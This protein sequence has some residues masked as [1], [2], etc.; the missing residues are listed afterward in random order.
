[1]L[2]LA[3]ALSQ[4]ADVTVAFRSIPE[5]V[6]SGEYKVIA[7]EPHA[8]T[9]SDAKDD[10]ATRGLHPFRHMSYCRRLGLFPNSR[11]VPMTS[12]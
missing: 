5:P 11:R 4:W 10:N 2:N 3:N 1:M 12:S 8:A 7:I 9:S 6:E